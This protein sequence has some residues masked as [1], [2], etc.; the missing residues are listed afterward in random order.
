MGRSPLGKR[1]KAR[2]PRSYTSPTDEPLSRITPHPLD[3]L[4]DSTIRGHV[5]NLFRG[6]PTCR[7]GG[8]LTPPGN[9]SQGAEL[10]RRHKP[11]IRITLRDYA[12]TSYS[13]DFCASSTLGEPQ[14]IHITTFGG[15]SP[16]GSSVEHPRV[17]LHSIDNYLYDSDGSHL[18][19]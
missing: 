2:I 4:S 6:T 3:Q 11:G 15:L 14:H 7:V 16:R 18:M 17:H 10:P 8:E 19:E 1:A 13:M 12:D 5:N 9:R